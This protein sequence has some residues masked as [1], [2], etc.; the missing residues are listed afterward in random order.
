[1]KINEYQKKAHDFADFKGNTSKG[2][3]YTVMG[4]SEEAG[5]VSGKFAKALRDEKG[6]ITKQRKRQ[7]SR[8]LE[9]YAGSLLR[10]PPC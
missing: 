8:N 4:L 7:Y 3:E 1:M 6:V 9:M 5:E 2:L 10:F